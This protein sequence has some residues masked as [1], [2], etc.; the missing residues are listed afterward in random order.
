[1]CSGSKSR[2]CKTVGASEDKPIKYDDNRNMFRAAWKLPLTTKTVPGASIRC[3][4]DK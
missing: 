4:G 2:M 1:M 3:H